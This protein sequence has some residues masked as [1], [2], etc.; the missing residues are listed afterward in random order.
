MYGDVFGEAI[1]RMLIAA[2]IIGGAVAA[3]L[4]FGIPWLWEI[5]KPWIHVVTA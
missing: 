4:I 1:I 5:V 2:F 3:A